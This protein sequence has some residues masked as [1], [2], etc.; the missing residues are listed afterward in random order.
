MTFSQL[1][2]TQQVADTDVLL[3]L[4]PKANGEGKSAQLATTNA[5]LDYLQH[6]L[7]PAIRILRI[8]EASHPAVVRSFH[9]TQ[10]PAF[11]LLR[12]GIELW[13][14]QG[15]TE[16]ESIVPLLLGKISN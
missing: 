12:Q 4:L 1:T 5:S 15:L 2:P 9:A 13:R 6:Q 7:G 16:G 3:V 14:H 10:L 11:V 8:D